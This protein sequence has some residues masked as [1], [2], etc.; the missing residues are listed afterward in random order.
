MEQSLGLPAHRPRSWELIVRSFRFLA[1]VTDYRRELG[2]GMGL[3][4]YLARVFAHLPVSSPPRIVIH[5]PDLAYPVTV[6][7]SPCSDEYVFDQL[8]VRKEYAAL[9][10]YLNN[11]RFIL[12]LGANVGFASAYFASRYPDARVLAVEPDPANFELCCQNLKPYGERVTVVQ[13][14]VW[15]CSTWLSLCY[16]AG[17]GWATQ[18]RLPDSGTDGLVQGRDMNTLLAMAGTEFADLV[19]IDIEGSE[20]EVFASNTNA[21]L[22]RVRHICIELHSDKCREV[23]FRALRE[24]D[25]QLRETGEFTLCLNLRARARNC[26]RAS[27]S[28]R[29]MGADQ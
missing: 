12:D 13:G 26:H 21:W 27:V 19:K 7:M 3:R 14:A 22:P 11:P 23:F 5:P 20:A 9:C 18:V 17:D 16:E 1:R 28:A 4:W 8:F 2:P 15:P 29:Y 6:R 10:E 25:Y 24:F